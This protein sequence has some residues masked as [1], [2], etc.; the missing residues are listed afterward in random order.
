MEKDEKKGV[1]FT[2]IGI[3]NLLLRLLI[4]PISFI[5]TFLVARYLS[6]YPYNETYFAAWQTLYVFTIG[7]FTIP[8]DLFSLITSRYSAEKRSVGGIVLLNLLSGILASM[9]FIVLVPYYMFLT[10]LNIPLYFYSAV[11]LIVLTYLLKITNAIAQG[12]TPKIVGVSA[13]I[14]QILRLASGL[15]FMYIY[16]F[17]ILAVILAY[18]IGYL[19]QILFNLFFIRANLKID[20]K[21][22]IAALRKS[23]VYIASYL[24]YILEASIVWI[25]LAI[26]ESNLIVAYF[27]SAVIISNI[28]IWSQSAYTGLIAKLAE[29]KNPS[30]ISNAIKLY[31]L[32]GSLFLMIIYLDGYGLLHKL[33]PDYT[34]AIIALYILTFSNFIRGIYTIFYQ[35]ITMVDKTLSVESKEEFKGYVARLTTM[36]MGLSLIGLGISSLLIYLLSSYPPYIIA[37]V[38]SIGILTNSFSMLFTSYKTSKSLY[39][40]SFP[41]REFLLPLA[42]GIIAIPFSMLYKPVSFLSMGS[43]ALLGILVFSLI[44]YFGNPY[45]K[46]IIITAIREFKQKHVSI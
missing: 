10:K 36:N 16:N 40:F 30:T 20:F 17:S 42:L 26:T 18:D 19:A 43:Y 11:S 1:R 39:N 44:N 4:A 33:R 13:T 46:Q 28:Q 29:D 31:S 7:Y 14:F 41:K 34:A 5:F 23:L 25:A 22:A 6:N 32:A 45:G 24:Q 37:G 2:R 35:S 15:I 38:M 9:I 21:I 3:S 12:R 8:A 27:E